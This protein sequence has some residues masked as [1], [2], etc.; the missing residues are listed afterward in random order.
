MLGFVKRGDRC[1]I[2]F[3]RPK[4]ATSLFLAANPSTVNVAH[5]LW[6][7][8]SPDNSKTE[9]GASK[10]VANA[11]VRLTHPSPHH[12]PLFCSSAVRFRK[13]RAK[14]FA[15]QRRKSTLYLCLPSPSEKCV[16]V[17]A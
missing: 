11:A 4:G 7:H 5:S 12:D 6:K 1:T 13:R 16:N 3:I 2:Y 15:G 17:N 10:N 8:A 14:P 9:I